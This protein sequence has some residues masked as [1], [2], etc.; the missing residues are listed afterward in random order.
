ML[1]IG[2]TSAIAS[3]TAKLFAGDNYSLFLVARNAEKLKKTENELSKIGT[4]KMLSFLM[5]VNDTGKHQEMLKAAVKGLGGLDIVFIAHGSNSVRHEEE[6]DGNK[7]LQEVN[8]NFGS[9]VS[10]LALI[11]DYFQKRKSGTIAVI[12]S[13]AGDKGRKRQYLYAS[14]K[15]GLTVFLEGLRQRLHQY[16]VSVVTIKP[17]LVRTPMTEH[18]KSSFLF[19][20]MPVI[21]K[22]IKNAILKKKDVAYIPGYWRYIMLVLRLI[23]EPLFKRLNF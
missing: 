10:I 3:E 20:D 6:S 7:I 19:S 2:A 18:I 14:C 12:S 4:G 5:D 21:A 9:T 11:A 17:G 23:P 15:A 16:N 1:I 13:V 8:T 22:G